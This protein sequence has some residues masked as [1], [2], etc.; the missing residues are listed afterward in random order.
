MKRILAV[1]LTFVMVLSLVACGDKGKAEKYCWSCGGGI[2]KNV[3]FCEHCGASVK[4]S[5]GE[6][7]TP[8]SSTDST[9]NSTT[10]TNG[11]TTT[12]TTTTSTTTKKPTTTKTAHTHSYSK[13]VIAATC[14][15]RGYT[16]YTCSCGDTYND[17]YTNPSHSYSQYVCTECGRLD[18]KHAYEWL[19]ELVKEEGEAFS[20]S[21]SFDIFGDRSYFLA[22]DASGDYLYI[23][24]AETTDNGEFCYSSL[25]LKSFFYGWSCGDRGTANFREVTGFLDAKNFTDNSP[26]TDVHYTGATSV[27]H[28]SV[29]TARLSMVCFIEAL[30]CIADQTEGLEM[31]IADLGFTA[32]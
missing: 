2:S 3:S 17:N 10:T 4:D 30:K 11:S 7:E 29:E 8:T 28:I 12:T 13:K 15:E 21:I 31:T 22:Y 32:Y 5:G 6:S 16:K 26:L 24:S 20:T 9:S 14:T 19:I 25:N 23:Y 27:K 1:V 18:K